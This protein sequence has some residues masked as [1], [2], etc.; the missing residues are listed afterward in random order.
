M[1][2]YRRSRSNNK[3]TGRST[4]SDGQACDPGRCPAPFT[5]PFIAIRSMEGIGLHGLRAGVELFAWSLIWERLDQCQLP[6]TARL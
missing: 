1:P 6:V 5:I 4:H 3:I 2:V